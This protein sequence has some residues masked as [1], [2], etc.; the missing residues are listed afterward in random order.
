MENDDVGHSLEP[1][2]R[3]LQNNLRQVLQRQTYRRVLQDVASRS[4]LDIARAHDAADVDEDPIIW[5][6]DNVWR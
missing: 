5:M 2:T 1:K 4:P 3:E 6:N